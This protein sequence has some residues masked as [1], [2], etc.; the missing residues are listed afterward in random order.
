MPFLRIHHHN[1][2]VITT[3]R[4]FNYETEPRSHSLAISSYDEGI[5]P[6]PKDRATLFVNIKDVNEPPV[7]PRDFVLKR[8]EVDIEENYPM[9][10]P[11]YGVTVT[12]E[13]KDD[14]DNLKFTMISQTSGP[15][16]GGLFFGIDP[17]HGAVSRTSPAPLDYDEGYEEFRLIMRATDPG[18]LYCEGG[19]IVYIED[20]N[21]EAPV[22]Q[23]IANDTIEVPEDTLVGSIIEVMKA[24]D[25]DANS[26]ISYF[27]PANLTMFT[28]NRR[29]GALVLREPLDYDHPDTPLAYSV[30]VIASD[31]V[32]NVSYRVTVLITNVDEQ[33]ICDPDISIGT[34]IVLTVPE[35]YP[36][37][38][39]LYTVLAKDPDYGDDVK[40][41]ISHSSPETTKY[42]NL[43]PDTGIISTTAVQLDYEMDPKKFVMS[44][45]VENK[46]PDSMSCTGLITITLQNE[47]DEA[48]IFIGLP[49]RPIEIPEN[50]PF[51]TVIYTLH[52]EDKDIGD[53]VHYEFAASYYGFFVDED[54]G[55]IR[56]SYPMDYED[57]TARHNQRLVVH[58][59]DNDRVHTTVADIRVRL[60]DVNDNYPQCD[61]YPNLI[62]VPETIPINT[63]LLSVVCVDKDLDP[64]NNVLK[65]KM[66]N[67]DSYSAD[68][69]K[70]T[71]NKLTIGPKGLDYDNVTF[72]GMQ[73]KHTL[74][75]EVSDQGAPSLTST[76]TVIVRVT[77]VNEHAP[78]QLLNEFTVLENSP[79]DSLVGTISFKDIDWPFNNMKFTFAGGDY[80]N[81]PRFY[82]EPKTGIIKVLNTLDA[83][84]QDLYT[85][86]IQAV[87]LNNDAQPD[88]LKQLKTFAIATI[89]LI[90]V[91]DE[92]P[93]CSPAYYE[94]LIYSTMKSSFL[95]LK[96][97]D[98]DSSDNELS[99][100]IVSGDRHNRFKLQRNSSSPPS[101][102]TNQNFQYDIFGGIKDP[103]VFQLLIQVTDEFGGKKA[104]QLSTTA[105]VI[106]HV[107][108]WTTTIPTTTTKAA[109]TTITTAIL[110]LR[111]YFWHPDSWFPAVITITAILFLLCLY[112]LAWCFFKDVPKCAKYFPFCKDFQNPQPSNL[113]EKKVLDQ[114]NITRKEEPIRDISKPE[115]PTT[116]PRIPAPP[117]DFFD[118][119]SVDPVSGNQFL[120]SS[121]TGKMQW[122]N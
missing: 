92:P 39:T 119:R 20:L 3:T 56:I 108:P 11:F 26:V 75:V 103:T 33:P 84:T 117:S 10:K 106:V 65:Y 53:T 76:V 52:A 12:D 30:F 16:T 113:P 72:A 112:G 8:V 15:K 107:V 89:E 2:G 28:L 69:F 88:P 111:S 32:H 6:I 110:V 22:F 87:D 62:E 99:Y 93:V 24:T 42:F 63:L 40:F 50:L 60:I 105:T 1:S 86:T 23:K 114:S 77:R 31:G 104:L 78:Q 46:K 100:S 64:P 13:D 51:G 118:I 81:P 102:V 25:R 14:A 34:G 21:D 58:A 95:Q 82:I 59:F 116:L 96:C 36:I 90:N 73:F 18:G 68:K 37:L 41:V 83:E 44:I 9:Y 74:L 91:N 55:E 27:F 43:N 79:V 67:L 7:C 70:L 97:S 19:L 101:L 49:S 71:D 17:N 115:N 4:S 66:T 57:T 29:T 122:L 61:G 120:Y 48:P 35:T 98:K 47:N 121:E 54:S 80:G 5:L 85:I 94:T 38:T 45:K 109:T